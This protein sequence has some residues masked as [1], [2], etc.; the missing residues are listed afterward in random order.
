MLDVRDPIDVHVGDRIRQRRKL[1]EQSQQDLAGKL[2]VTFQQVQKY[3]RGA[4]R[5]SASMM[6]RAARAQG[7]EPNYYFEGLGVADEPAPPTEN[8]GVIAWLRSAEAVTFGIA[9]LKVPPS[10]RL[11]LLRMIHNLDNVSDAEP[12][13]PTKPRQTSGY[14]WPPRRF[15]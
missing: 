10:V 3:E 15:P 4:N 5:I 12:W 13:K 6:C 14:I 2:G 9:I 8:T 1:I 7:V 11:I